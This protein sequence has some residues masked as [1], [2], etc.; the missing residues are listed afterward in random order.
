[1]TLRICVFTI[2]TGFSPGAA[3]GCNWEGPA[4]LRAKSV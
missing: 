1:L 2:E 3:I 4:G